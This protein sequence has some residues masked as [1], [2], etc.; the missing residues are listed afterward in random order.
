MFFEN[1]ILGALLIFLIRSL[2]IAVATMRILMM[3][4]GPKIIVFFLAL[5]EAVAFAVTFGQVAANLSNIWNLG[6]YS[7]GFAAGTWVGTLIE[8]AIGQGYATLNVVSIGRSQP[9]AEAIRK[10]G[11][12]ATRSTGEGTTGTVGLVRAVVTR[13]DVR[14]LNQL[15]HGIDPEAFVTIEETRSVSRGFLGYGRS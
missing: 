1:P 10:A 6:A 14:Q 8:E 15:I 13:K 11:F 12:G 4:R 2:S 7:L 3:G 9:I 5:F